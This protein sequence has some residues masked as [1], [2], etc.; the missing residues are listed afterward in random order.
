MT[1]K[2]QAQA[3]KSEVKVAM[4]YK[5]FKAVAMRF[6]NKSKPK[7]RVTKDCVIL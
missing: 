7:M 3:I 5:N 1:V 4:R 2:L 6:E